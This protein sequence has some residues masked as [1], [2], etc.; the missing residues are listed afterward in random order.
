MVKSLLL[1]LSIGLLSACT[2]TEIRTEYVSVPVACPT[3]QVGA[4]KQSIESQT[5]SA[6]RKEGLIC[7]SE[8]DF[9]ELV[10]HTKESRVSYNELMSHVKDFN[11]MV[12]EKNQTI[13]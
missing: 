13:K 7:M 1:I 10:I 9:K 8:Y 12:E 5:F 3:V 11:E 2:T 4:F 6:R